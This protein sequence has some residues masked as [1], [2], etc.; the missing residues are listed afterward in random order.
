VFE[1]RSIGDEF[2]P[3]VEEIDYLL[4]AFA[5]D[6]LSEFEGYL[7]KIRTNLVKEEEDLN[8]KI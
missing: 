5:R 3:D 8:Y 1:Y 6:D 4:D 7:S 2:K